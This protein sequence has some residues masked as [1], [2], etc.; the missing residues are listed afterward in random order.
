MKRMMVR[1]EGRGERGAG[2]GERGAGSGE[3]G[4]GSGQ[5]SGERGEGRGERG[6]GRREAEHTV[7]WECSSELTEMQLQGCC[8]EISSYMF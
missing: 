5:W 2:S 8:S 1:R 4:V 3:W 7:N 6:D